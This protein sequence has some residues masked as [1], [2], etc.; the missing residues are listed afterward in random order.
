MI[1]AWEK[2]NFLRGRQR[3][4]QLTF[5]QPAGQA[6]LRDL[7]VFCRGM[8]SCFH[9]DPRLHAVAEGRREVLLRIL[10]HLKMTPEDLYAKLERDT[11]PTEK[12]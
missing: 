3:S 5:S 4:Y 9:P 1:D 10:N 8:D 2:F 6:V 7:I 11:A 12:P